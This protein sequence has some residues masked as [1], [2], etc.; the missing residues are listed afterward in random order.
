MTMTSER[1]R[2]VIVEDEPLAA[3]TLSDFVREVD[4]LEEVGQA[5]DGAAALDLIARVQPDVVFLDI[6]LPGIDGIEI[7][8][9]LPAPAQ[10]V[11][12]TA[13]DHYAVTAF[14]LGAIDYLLKPFSRA[15]WQTAIDRLQRRRLTPPV[16]AHARFL[17]GAT[18]PIERVFVWKF[19]DL[20]PVRDADIVLVQAEGDYARLCTRSDQYLVHVALAELERRLDPSRFFRVHRSAIVNIDHVAR[21]T[22]SDD[23]RARITLADGRTVTASR[24]GTRV[25]LARF[26]I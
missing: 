2:V 22:K 5:A 18:M 3:H 24:T 19:N 7:L 21:L 6:R 14:E 20:I 1:L 26:Q 4:W 23:G 15:R 10:V 13:Y 25:L 17:A 8:G 12:T 16:S 9:R 11:F